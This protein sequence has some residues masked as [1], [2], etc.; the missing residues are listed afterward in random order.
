M[1]SEGNQAN[2]FAV[3][4]SQYMSMKVCIPV[5]ICTVLVK[6]DSLYISRIAYIYS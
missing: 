1:L 3:V 2:V 5:T 6:L 4:W